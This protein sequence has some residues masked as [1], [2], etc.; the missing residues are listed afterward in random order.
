MDQKL[1]WRCHLRIISTV[2][3]WISHPNPPAPLSKNKNVF[4]SLTTDINIS[5]NCMG[6]IMRAALSCCIT[7]QPG[8]WAG[9][10]QNL[11]QVWT[12]WVIKH[13]PA[14]LG[15]EDQP[16]DFGSSW[17]KHTLKVSFPSS[18]PESKHMQCQH[19]LPAFTASPP[20]RYFLI[21]LLRPAWS[22]KSPLL[23]STGD[24]TFYRGPPS[25]RSHLLEINLSF[26]LLVVNL[27]IWQQ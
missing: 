22:K 6:V 18:T 23:K 26:E 21:T 10:D 19:T 17:S 11:T 16:T 2:S 27:N 9:L 24:A 14:Q 12:F 15:V 25:P 7:I 1:T 20:H 3:F 4:P 13:L 5:V 8:S